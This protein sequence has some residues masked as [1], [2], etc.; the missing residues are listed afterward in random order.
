[1]RDIILNSK[2]SMSL[3]PRCSLES[4]DTHMREESPG[5]SDAEAGGNPKGK[6]IGPPPPVGFWHNGLKNT[7]IEVLKAWLKTSMG[8][9]EQTVFRLWLICR[10]L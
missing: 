5:S 4:T 3:Q 8:L 1:M 9:R 6:S 2:D 7:R 10:Q